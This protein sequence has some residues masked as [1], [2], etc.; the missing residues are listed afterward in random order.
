MDRWQVSF[1][2]FPHPFFLLPAWDV[3]RKAGA[4]A[5]VPDHETTIKMEVLCPGWLGKNIERAWSLMIME[6][7]H[8][9]WTTDLWNSS[10][11]KNNKLLSRLSHWCYYSLLPALESHPYCIR[12][13]VSV[14]QLVVNTA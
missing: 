4:S 12:A 3:A 14:T 2:S 1:L 5:A 7:P 9:P 11:G 13:G 10:V 6:L 8:W